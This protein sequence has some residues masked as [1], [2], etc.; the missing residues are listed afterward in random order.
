MAKALD[1]PTENG[2]GKPLNV[3]DQKDKLLDNIGAQTLLILPE[4]KRLPA[5]IR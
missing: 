3:D 5:S 1:I 2:E 4:A